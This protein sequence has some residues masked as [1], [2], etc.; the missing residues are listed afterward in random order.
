MAFP[1]QTGK[2]VNVG[3][4]PD[5][6]RFRHFVSYCR[7]DG[8]QWQL[9]ESQGRGKGTVGRVLCREAVQIEHAQPD[10]QVAQGGEPQVF[11]VRRE[12]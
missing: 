6:K 3:T 9:G 11:Q 12:E 8:D 10:A 7:F 5:R 2:R 4:E 1:K